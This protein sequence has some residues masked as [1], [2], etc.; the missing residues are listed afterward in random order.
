MVCQFKRLTFAVLFSI[1]SPPFLILRYGRIF[2]WFGKLTTSYPATIKDMFRDRIFL[3]VLA[4][5]VITGLTNNISAKASAYPKDPAKVGDEWTSS[6]SSVLVSTPLC[7]GL[8]TQ[9]CIETSTFT[10]SVSPPVIVTA[11]KE[12]LTS[13]N[14]SIQPETLS[15][16]TPSPTEPTPQQF[17]NLDS[18]KIFSL[19]NQYRAS[20]GL[21]PFEQE[22]SVCEL[23]QIRSVELAGEL[24]N[25]TIHSGLYNRTLPYWIWENAKLGSN[26]EDTVSWWLSSPLHHQSIIGDYKY[27]CVKCT[28]TN[29]S[30]LFTS[31]SPK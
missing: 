11:P 6:C 24:T 10:T 28:G 21:S 23:A 27:S 5:L 9:S 29:C 19:I 8:L 18:D 3:P 14:I 22:N 13:E 12:T 16:S 31:F 15:T 20:Q 7:D 30:Q 1:L 2:L 17:V 25:G 4:F 26:E